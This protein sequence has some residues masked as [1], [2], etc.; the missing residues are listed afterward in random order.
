MCNVHAFIRGCV[1]CGPFIFRTWVIQVC[2]KVL[3]P[4]GAAEEV[5]GKVGAAFPFK[6]D[7]HIGPRAVVT[8]AC[9]ALPTTRVASFYVIV[10][11]E[12]KGVAQL[13]LHHLTVFFSSL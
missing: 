7:I 8:L 1:N 13:T 4:A 6:P 12:G 2:S 10:E 3:F 11:L 5:E 9:G